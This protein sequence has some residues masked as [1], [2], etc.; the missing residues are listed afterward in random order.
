MTSPDVLRQTAFVFPG[1]GSQVIGMGRD[2]YDHESLAR[3]TFD[4]ADSL[5]DL[6]LSRLCFEGPEAELNDTINTQPALFVT[7]VAALRVLEARGVCRPAFVAGHS[8][9]EISALVA[10]GALAFADGVRLVRERGRL[11]KLAGERNPGG[12]AA[13]LGLERQALDEVCAEA[14][15]LTKRPVQ[16][17]NDNCPGQ[18]VISGDRNALEAALELAKARGA[19]RALPLAVSIAAHSALMAVVA[20]DFAQTVEATPFSD[21][22]TPIVGN[23]GAQPLTDVDAIRADLSAQLTAPVA[24]TA[25]VRAMLAQGVTTFVEVGSKDVLTGLLKRIDPNARGLKAGD[26]AGI[27]EVVDAL[28]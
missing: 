5:L 15:E 16:V 17:A 19:K 9:G 8:L 14:M 2:L 20:D 25:S 10:A 3:A 26:R 4:E 27:E 21:P 24:W 22:Q 11:M 1:Q 7:S 6:P 12:M 28:G 13:I 23:V 18:L